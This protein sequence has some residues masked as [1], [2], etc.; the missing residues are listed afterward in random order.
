MAVTRKIVGF[1]RKAL[2]NGIPRRAATVAAV[3]APILILINQGDALFGDASFHLGKAM[4]TAVVPYLVATAGAVSALSGDSTAGATMPAGSRDALDR[5]RQAAMALKQSA[6]S[7]QQKTLAGR[8]LA[9]L[10]ELDEAIALSA[11]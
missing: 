7:Q 4:L 5:A 6:D 8:V 11:S 2:S 10:E 1:F 9:N 3:V